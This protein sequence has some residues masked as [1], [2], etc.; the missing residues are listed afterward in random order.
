MTQELT[1]GLEQ[2]IADREEKMEGLALKKRYLEFISPLTPEDLLYLAFFHKQRNAADITYFLK[3]GATLS[4]AAIPS[5]THAPDAFSAPAIA[6]PERETLLTWAVREN[7]LTL[8]KDLLDKGVALEHPNGAGFT[9]LQLAEQYGH[10]HLAALLS[11]QGEHAELPQ[12]V[13]EKTPRESKEEAHRSASARSLPDN[14][15][16]VISPPADL[17]QHRRATSLQVGFFPDLTG[18]EKKRQKRIAQLD[19]VI[20]GLEIEIACYKRASDCLTPNDLLY[21]AF[22]TGNPKSAAYF[23]REIPLE[24][25]PPTLHTQNSALMHFFNKRYQEEGFR[26]NNNLLIHLETPLTCA[27]REGYLEVVKLLLK[28]GADP[29][30]AN[31]CAETALEIGGALV[32]ESKDENSL[33]ILKLLWEQKE[34]IRLEEAAQ[35]RRDKELAK[36]RGKWSDDGKE[37][38]SEGTE[39]D[40]PPAQDA[41][42]TKLRREAAQKEACRKASGSSRDSKDDSSEETPEEM[43]PESVLYNF[44]QVE[45][46]PWVQPPKQKWETPHHRRHISERSIGNIER[47][48]LRSI[49]GPA[50]PPPPQRAGRERSRAP[51]SQAM[52]DGVTLF[53]HVVETPTRILPVRCAS[54]QSTDTGPESPASQ[55]RTGRPLEVNRPILMPLPPPIPSKKRLPSAHSTSLS[56]DLSRPRFDLS[57]LKFWKSRKPVP[58][59]APR[60]PRGTPYPTPPPPS[61]FE[62]AEGSASLISRQEPPS[63]RQRSVRST[64]ER[65]MPGRNSVFNVREEDMRH[66]SKTPFSRPPGR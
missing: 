16:P 65:T 59:Q 50:A 44:C 17:P 38:T 11:R 23:L 36:E 49:Q 66:F 18:Q 29:R 46:P 28:K 5:S 2:A 9:A 13:E 27:V 45:K 34:K 43:L 30:Q 8:V 20:A 39:E 24:E 35:F 4:P 54:G 12:V 42:F 33:S 14:R 15:G 48:V 19:T 1:A 7:H 32:S 47:A 61:F 3:K 6:D 58:P 40:S 62:A 64:P 37:A 25:L 52:R 10:T 53:D 41:F 56:Q 55:R 51:S 26:K 60:H 57:R 21:I 31:R 63:T 22:R